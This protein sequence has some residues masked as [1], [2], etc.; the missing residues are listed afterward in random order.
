MIGFWPTQ[1]P[2]GYLPLPFLYWVAFRFGPSRVAVAGLTMTLTANVMS[3]EG[4][5]PW[6]V[7]GPTARLGIATLQVFLVIAIAGAWILAI[8]VAEREH[9]QSASRADLAARLRAQE[10]QNLTARL[11]TAPTSKAVC[12]AVVDHGIKLIAEHGVVGF[13]TPDG[14]DLL[15]WTTD[16]FPT[17]VVKKFHRLPIDA[18]TPITNTVATESMKTAQSLA[19]IERDFPETLASYA[20]MGTNSC[21]TVPACNGRDVIGALSFGFSKEGAIDADT[22]AF[23][24]NIASLTG[25][26]LERARRYEKEYD[27]AHALQRALLPLIESSLPG[28]NAVARYR[29][30]DSDH[31]VGGDWY[32]LFQLPH[33]RIG[34]VVG[35]VVGHDLQA[36]VTMSRLQASLR[37]IAAAACGPADVLDQ[38]DVIASQIPGAFMST[39]AYAEYDSVTRCLQYACAGHLPFLIVAGGEASFLWDGRS[40]PLGVSRSSR[41]QAQVAIPVDSRLV[42]FTDGLI[43]RRRESID[44]GLQ[45]L[46]AVANDLQL[47]DADSWC[48]AVMHELVG[49]QADDDLVLL[50]V[51]FTG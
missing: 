10:L 14:N 48:D 18:P 43:E 9:A 3:A 5:G 6:G 50:C 15:T 11:A 44:S 21:L 45:R 8:E 26:A 32:D 36:A 42:G 19:E 40:G 33:G 35:D 13:R 1:V 16:G 28:V 17:D 34:L 39:V 31:D 12:Q 30:A 49:L 25:Q 46:S 22:I 47:L 23:A 4:R 37:V 41:E 24:Q 29:P 7:V 27:D 38:L 51:D 2:L 20:A